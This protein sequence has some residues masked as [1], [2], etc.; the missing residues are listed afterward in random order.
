MTSRNA[1]K[2]RI[3]SMDCASC[4]SKI[5]NALRRLPG[6]SDISVNYGQASMSLRV[7][8][9]Q[10]SRTAIEERIRALGFAATADTAAAG[11]ARQSPMSA[12]CN[13]CRVPRS[14]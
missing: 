10:T 6:V 2:Y 5:E 8:E 3:E 11:G 7:D 14:G 9:D 4:A 1:L 13:S 12:A